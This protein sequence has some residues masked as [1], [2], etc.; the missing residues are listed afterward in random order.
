MLNKFVSGLVTGLG[1]SI[2][3][4]IVL[5][6]WINHMAHTSV[7]MTVQDASPTAPT[8]ENPSHFE[9]FSALSLDEKIA[10][11]TAIFVTTIQK[12]QAGLYEPR[13]TEILKKQD[14]TELYYQVGDT[15]DDG[16]DYNRHE[17][18]GNPIPKG[19][20]VFMSGNPASMRYA[21][22]HS[23]DRINTLGGI[24]IE[25]LRKKCAP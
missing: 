23:G 8:T 2:S 19:F 4:I 1:F 6:I 15:Y 21:V 12:N 20:I 10:K 3:L 22:S 24:S 14:D 25:L 17:R 7:P 18:E 5:S 11:S 13:V 9:D 16:H